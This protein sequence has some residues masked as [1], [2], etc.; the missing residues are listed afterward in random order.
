MF[1]AI[2]EMTRSL[3]RLFNISAGTGISLELSFL[4]ASRATGV[5]PLTTRIRTGIY[6]VMTG[7][8]EPG[9]PGKNRPPLDRSK[10][11]VNHYNT[12]FEF[13]V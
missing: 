12:E 4:S 6:A 2:K 8:P 13:E 10:I 9:E 5:C 1:P 11:S 3:Y 7:L